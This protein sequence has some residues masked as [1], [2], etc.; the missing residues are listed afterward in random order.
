MQAQQIAVPH[1]WRTAATHY[2]VFTINDKLVAAS[3]ENKQ[4]KRSLPKFTPRCYLHVPC[5]M[6]YRKRSSCQQSGGKD[7]FVLIDWESLTPH[8]LHESCICIHPHMFWESLQQQQRQQRQQQQQQQNQRLFPHTCARQTG[9][10]DCYAAGTKNSR[11]QQQA[12]A[13]VQLV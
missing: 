1:I 11:R 5:S 13:E 12:A 10:Q 8:S 7:R 3:G 2:P 9:Q 6:C 4:W